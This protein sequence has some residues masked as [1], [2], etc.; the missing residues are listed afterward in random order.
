MYGNSVNDSSTTVSL[1]LS[2]TDP[3]LYTANS[4][5]G[6][7][8]FSTVQFGSVQN[9]VTLYAAASSMT[10]TTSNPFNVV[11]Q[12][13]YAVSLLFTT[14]PNS[15]TS[16]SIFGVQP[17]V[18][19]VDG[20]GNIVSDY[21][22]S[23]LLSV[24]TGPGSLSGTVVSNILN[25][26]ATFS[27]LSLGIAGLNYTLYAS[28]I[29]LIGVVSNNFVVNGEARIQFGV[30]PKTTF[31]EAPISCSI[32]VLDIFGNVLTT[33]SLQITLSIKSGTGSTSSISGSVVSNSI[34]GY[35][36][37]SSAIISTVGSNYQ[38]TATALNGL[39]AY[40][41][42]FNIIVLNNSSSTTA[43][44]SS[45]SFSWSSEITTQSSI[46][47]TT[48]QTLTTL[49]PS[50]TAST[51]S[52][53]IGYVTSNYV[54]TSISSS[55]PSSSSKITQW[56]TSSST[57]AQWTT[58]SSTE[59]QWTTTTH[60][61]TMFSMASTTVVAYKSSVTVTTQAG[62]STGAHS[63]TATSFTYPKS[64]STYPVSSSVPPDASTTQVSS[65]LSNE[66]STWNYGITDTLIPLD[67]AILKFSHSC[68]LSAKFSFIVSFLLMFA[69]INI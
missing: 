29:G 56:T 60:W 4:S 40:S 27:D 33:S 14:Q 28:S 18:G 69:N 13:G 3:V 25:G 59:S 53:T 35:A 26:Y 50:L 10:P 16:G 12:S 8:Q 24:Q 2:S 37:F 15:A 17:I 36:N 58:S 48:S 52:T 31:L 38:L 66:F 43:T 41:N 32:E 44:P 57:A 61:T 46:L 65:V 64:S 23:V 6:F 62:A 51:T 1:R 54:S 11:A 49:T 42:P 68:K 55:A 20:L 67:T 9:S 30:Q 34:N 21:S 63:S 5:N 45:V 39:L 47:S 19:V 22:G 7:V